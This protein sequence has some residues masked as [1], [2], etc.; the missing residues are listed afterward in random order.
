MSSIKKAVGVRPARRQIKNAVDNFMAFVTD[1]NGNTRSI[2]LP[3][4]TTQIQQQNIEDLNIVHEVSIEPELDNYCHDRFDS[5]SDHHSL[6]VSSDEDDSEQSQNFE[7]NCQAVP[8][9]DQD[10]QSQLRRWAIVENVT[11]KALDSLLKIL[12]SKVS[13]LPRTARTLLQP[14]KVTPIEAICNG[15]FHYRGL[16][17]GILEALLLGVKHHETQLSLKFNIDG[18][19]LYNSS[20]Q[21]CWPILGVVNEVQQHVPFVIAAFLGLSKPSNLSECLTPFVNDLKNICETGITFK[22]VLF[23]INAS[24]C[25]F[26]ADAPSRAFLKST[27]GHTGYFGCER[28]TSKGKWARK[29]IFPDFKADLRTDESFSNRLQE[30]HHSRSSDH[31]TPLERIGIGMISQIPID[32]MHLVYTGV[33]KG[34]SNY[35]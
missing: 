9:P 22:S 6:S 19:P 10:F 1:T 25:L 32:P 8:N 33:T 14:Q 24:K 35:G 2:E 21:S 12:S 23:T 16:K 5:D 29:V 27:V 17:K 18:I 7:D 34:S 20:N 28:C 31:A 26:I 4:L 3:C 30:Q 13:D 11:H 15:N